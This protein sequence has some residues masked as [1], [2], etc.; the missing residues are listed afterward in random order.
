V[1]LQAPVEVTA[2][3]RRL[4]A[5]DELERAGR[6]AFEDLRQSF[7]LARGALRILLGRSLSVTPDSIR[8]TYGGK[9]KP[10][11]AAPGR[12]RFNVSH[13][14][15]LVLI[16]ATLDC[17]IGV[18]I[19]KIRPATDVHEIAARFF[20]AEEN[21]DLMSLAADQREAAFF[22]CWTRK[23]AYIKA[24]GD[25]LSAPLDRFAVSLGPGA[26]ARMVHIG[27]DADEA[28]AW[29]LHDLAVEPEYAAALAYRDSPRGIQMSRPLDPAELLRN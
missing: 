4:L 29:T 25:G 7:T 27:G 9:G 20:C 14:D 11:L 23:E 15:R 19:E 17:E 13:S 8:F 6:F 3:F 22:R 16:A 18:D 21:V 28:A 24:T 2:R 12:L 26:A 1:R 10:S 5:D